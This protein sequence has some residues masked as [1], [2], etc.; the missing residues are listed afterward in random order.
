MWCCG[1]PGIAAAI[2]GDRKLIAFNVPL[3]G[4]EAPYQ[5]NLPLL[6]RCGKTT[7]G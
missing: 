4:M 1:W 2:G 6:R 3:E 5:N 7:E